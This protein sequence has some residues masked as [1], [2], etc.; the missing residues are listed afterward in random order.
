MALVSFITLEYKSILEVRDC[1]NAIHDGCE[2]IQHEVIISSN[3]L[4]TK[5]EQD[6]ARKVIDNARWV[7]NERNGG[8]AYGMNKGLAQAEGDFLV[9]CNSKTKILEGINSL[10]DYMRSHEEI[11]AIGPQLIDEDGNI[12]DSCRQYVTVQDFIGRQLKRVF[13]R[14]EVVKS[15]HIDYHEIQYVDWIIGA[16]I[17]MRKDVYRQTK[18][19]DEDF[20]MYAEDLDLGIR[21]NQLGYKVCYFPMAKVQYKG[22]RRARHSIKYALIFLQSHFLL[23]RKHGFFSYK[24]P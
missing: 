2:G 6:E 4:Y 20:F 8:F 3:S 13:L 5:E 11:G 1:V 21:I 9:I 22:T 14:K 16:F 7:F 19:F 17:I 23:W 24:H 10:L 15:P 18:G 12:Q